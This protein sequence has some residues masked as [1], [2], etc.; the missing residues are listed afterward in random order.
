MNS[1]QRFGYFPLL[2]NSLL[3]AVFFLLLPCLVSAQLNVTMSGVSPTCNGWTN[4]S[5]GATVTNGTPPYMFSWNGGAPTG[6]NTIASVGAG[7]YDVVVTDANNQTGTG[8]Y[9]LTE[10]DAIIVNVTSSGGCA[11]GTSATAN[12]TG[13]TGGYSYAWDNGDTGQ[14]TSGLSFG[15]HCVTVTDGSGCQSVGCVTISNGLSINMVVQGLACFN[16]CDASVE[17][18]VSGG[19]PPYTYSWNNGAM[20][21]VNENLGPGTYDV[22]VTDAAGCTITGSATVTNPFQID[23]DVTV[24][25]PPCAS[26]GTG[27]AS[28]SAT[29]GTAPYTYSWSNGATG[30]SVSGLA[31]GTYGLTVTDF[32]GCQGITSV[33]VI[34]D[35]G[36]ELTISPTP[37]SGCGAPDGSA[38][39]NIMGGTAPYSV[40]WSNGS[41]GTTATGLAPGTY[42]VMVTD[43]DGCGATATT[44]ITGTPAIDL[45]IN[46]VNAGCAANGSANAMVTPGTGTPPFQ[47]NWS[48]GETTAIINNITAGT[49]SV[50]VTDNAGCTATDQITVSGSSDIMVSTNVNSTSCFNVADGSATANVTGAMGQIFYM[51]SNGGST[52]T[53]GGLSAGTYFVTVVDNA[54]GCTATTNAFVSQPTEV[55]VTA[56]GTNAGCNDPGSAEA[57]ASGGTAPYSYVWSN[58]ATTQMIGNLTGG[59]Y[60]VTATDANGCMDEASVS[61]APG[62]SLDVM[63]EVTNPIS[64]SNADDGSVEANVTGGVAPYTYLWNT[65]ATTAEITGLSGGTY[66]VTVTDAEGCTGTGSVNLVELGCIGDR[67]WED[68]NRD[69]CQ[70]PGEIGMG[71]ITVTLTGTDNDGNAVNMSTVTLANGYYLFDNLNPGNYTVAFGLPNNYAFSPANDCSDDFTDSDVNAN[72]EVSINL[73][74]GHCNVTVDAGIYDDCLNVSDP[75]EIC[76]DQSLCGPG[77]D[78]DPINSVTPASGGG[79]PIEY[80]WM[81]SNVNVPFNPNSWAP[82]PGATGPSYDP[83]PLQVTTYFIRCTKAAAC[84]EWKESNVVTVV[85]GMEAFAE[86]TGPDLVCVGDPATYI[87]TA[88]PAGATYSWDFGPWATPSTSN[89]PT[90]TVTWNQFGVVYITLTVQAGNCTSV[91]ELGVAIS[92]SPILCGNGLIINTNEMSNAVGVEWEMEKMPGDYSFVVQRSGDGVDFN[93]LAAMPQ[94]QEDGMHQ[95]SFTDYFP[96]KGNSIYRVQIMEGDQ[97]HSFSNEVQIQRFEEA[98]MFVTY[99]NPVVDRMRVEI[100]NDISTATKAELLSVQG[101]LISSDKIAAGTMNHSIDMSSL[102]SGVYFVRL[103]YN[104]GEKET[105][106]VVKR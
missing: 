43:A 104:N 83:G 66:S 95:Y 15:V 48:S 31:P 50:T 100:S 41:T 63:V 52:Q 81:Y 34:E 51:W 32:L 61:I 64:G 35:S 58:G 96:K 84:N 60:T 93:T 55:E 8:S 20:G 105:I 36:V 82:I 67:V 26:G 17:A 3:Q 49:Y 4:G 1:N 69:G 94:S 9:N 53:I 97:H 79:S 74:Q 92:N 80:M 101:K 91:S 103:T 98:E 29:G 22:T 54:T 46:G 87:A 19:T 106:R 73:A 28:A 44:T 62:G 6:S 85:V 102:R 13:G 39:V 71:G 76:C 47:Y 10:P 30:S 14:S 21:P 25:N 90:A 59:T 57:S 5:V 45:N 12:V 42:D 27:S 56:I 24:T 16:F 40:M 11:G 86:I 7:T 78:P 70:D 89:D 77:N 75:G 37:S 23:I 2:K 68:T 72:G 99:P 33:A 88:N 38:T 18:V 65:G